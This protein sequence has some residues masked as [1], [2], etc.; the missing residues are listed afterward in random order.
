M[1]EK[2]VLVWTYFC[3]GNANII[4]DGVYILIYLNISYEYN[5]SMNVEVLNSALETT[6]LTDALQPDADFLSGLGEKRTTEA[7]VE[8]LENEGREG[9][10]KLVE[11]FNNLTGIESEAAALGA[12]NG[13]EFH[14][15]DSANTTEAQLDSGQVVL[16]PEARANLREDTLQL[17]GQ[18]HEYVE[19][20]TTQ[21]ASHYAK[22]LTTGTISMEQVDFIRGKD[23]DPGTLPFSLTD[24]ES[25]RLQQLLESTASDEGAQQVIEQTI[26]GMIRDRPTIVGL[27][28][29]VN[30]EGFLHTVSTTL[31]DTGTT[32]TNMEEI[33]FLRQAM[34]GDC[35]DELLIHPGYLEPSIKRLPA[36]SSAETPTAHANPNAIEGEVVYHRGEWLVTDIDQKTKDWL[37]NS[38]QETLS[39]QYSPV[40]RATAEKLQ[41]GFL[42]ELERLSAAQPNIGEMDPLKALERAENKHDDQEALKLVLRIAIKVGT[43]VAVTVATELAK[44]ENTPEELKVLLNTFAS[45]TGEGGKF[46]DQMISGN[47]HPNLA[48]DCTNFLRSRLEENKSE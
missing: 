40:E 48:Q 6:R 13:S 26:Q 19:T 47:A 22:G 27:Q 2:L 37:T 4:A 17:S 14:M 38:R 36:T 29:S 32:H 39:H 10:A 15:I 11:V 8:H 34:Q 31:G 7:L 12:G 25:A 46:A 9:S 41:G 44:S 33:A 28:D 5:I 1:I 18:I 20:V 21:T 24:E 3:T 45:L 43:K 30:L 42:A 23:A 16:L 35:I